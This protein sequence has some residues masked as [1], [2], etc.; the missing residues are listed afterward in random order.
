MAGK[1]IELK[2]AAEQLGLTP[3]RLLE[4]RDA[5]DAHGYRDGK[6]WK[7]KAEEIDR[8][9]ESLAAEGS[10]SNGASDSAPL[11][12]DDLDGLLDVKLGDD[13]D[14]DLESSSILIS[15]DGSGDEDE[16]SSSS[17]VIGKDDEASEEG[18]DLK[19]AADSVVDGDSGISLVPESGLGSDVELVADGGDE[20]E[21]QLADDEDLSDELKLSDELDFESDDALMLGEDSGFSM[22]SDDEQVLDGSSGEL[23]IASSDSGINVGSPSDSGLL[24]EDSAGG[25][26][27][28]LPEDDEMVSMDN[29]VEPLSEDSTQLPQ[30]EEFLLSPSGDLLGEE[31]S[32]SGS[33]VIALEDSGSFEDEQGIELGDSAEPVLVADDSDALESQ[34]EAFDGAAVESGAVPMGAVGLPEAPYSIWNILALLSV[35]A[36]LGVTGM[37]MSDIVRNMWAWSGDSSV[38]SGLAN[39]IVD[40]LGMK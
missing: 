19:L 7:F 36:L 9:A 5:G 20:D 33:Q 22:G 8:L 30:D 23:D 39:S 11:S 14:E 3:E 31:S 28:E 34:L 6:S 21:L 40:M 29:E 10:S 18:S 37:L 32:D 13:A 16:E 12:G 26:V 35:V 38:A 27:L 17:T 1:F 24:L 2:Q 15:E 4:M 25:E